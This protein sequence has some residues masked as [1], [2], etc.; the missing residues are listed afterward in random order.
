MFESF[1][2]DMALSGPAAFHTCSGHSAEAC[3]CHSR[4]HCPFPVFSHMV[5][6]APAVAVTAGCHVPG[7]QCVHCG[8][9]VPGEGRALGRR[10]GGWQACV[11]SYGCLSWFDTFSEQNFVTVTPLLNSRCTFVCFSHPHMHL[12][13]PVATPRSS[14]RLLTLRCPPVHVA[15]SPPPPTDHPVPGQA[16]LHPRHLLRHHQQLGQSLLLGFCALPLERTHKGDTGPQ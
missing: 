3:C 15:L 11:E 9:D 7:I 13:S 5:V 4:S 1:S 10:G 2:P 16:A 8:L 12:V 14:S 6:C